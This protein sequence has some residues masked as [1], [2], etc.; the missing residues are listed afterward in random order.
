MSKFETTTY[1]NTKQIVKFPDHYVNQSIEVTDT[2]IT[3]VDGRKILP[4]GTIYPANDATAQGVL[5]NDVDVTHGPAGGALLIHGFVD[6]DKIP[7]APSDEAK[8]ALPL[9]KFL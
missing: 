2:G 9:I 8:A 3:A 7:T 4:A 5:F 6:L 1:G